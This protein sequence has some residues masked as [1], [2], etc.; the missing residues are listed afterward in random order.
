MGSLTEGFANLTEAML[1]DYGPA[2]PGVRRPSTAAILTSRLLKPMLPSAIR[3]GP[4]GIVDLKDR[5]AGPFDV[6]GTWDIFP[7]ISSHTSFNR[8]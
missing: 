7:A 5:Q 4:G 2:L 8:P 6:V 1:A 3:C